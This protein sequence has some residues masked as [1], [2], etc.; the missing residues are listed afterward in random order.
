MFSGDRN[1][2]NK[3]IQSCSAY[4][5]LNTEIFN[6]NKKKILFVLSY[7]TEGTAE[8]WKE[9][10]MDKKNGAYGLYPTF[11]DVLKKAFSAAD[12]E[13]KAWAQLRHL[14]Q[15]KDGV[16]KYITQFRILAGRAKLTDDKTL[17]EYFIEGINTWILQ[18]IFAQNPLPAMIN[19]WYT[20]ATKFDSQHRRCYEWPPPFF[21][22]SLAILTLP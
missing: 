8:A 6:S 11:I 18:K 9:V 1:D 19:D 13:G 16:D 4:L 21:L 2:L 20:S 3:F 12:T 5:N 17:V 14:R 22:F 10:Y 15:G 7:M